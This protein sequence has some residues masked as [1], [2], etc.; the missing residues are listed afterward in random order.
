MPTYYSLILKSFQHPTPAMHQHSPH[1]APSITYGK[2]VQ[3]EKFDN[4]P[5]LDN[6]G[7]KQVQSIVGSILYGARL[8]DNPTLVA[9]NE[10]G[11]QKANSTMNTLKLCS[12]LLDYVA[13]YP[14]PSLTCKR[15]DVIF[16]VASDSSYLSAPNS[17][18]RVGGHHLL[19]NK[20]DSKIP[21]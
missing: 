15:S 6:H 17:R 7:T 12:W 2:S 11:S 4:A 18:I 1:P 8:I 10:I 19:G 21:I 13:T 9:V 14:N 3:C 16:H 20:I 5:K